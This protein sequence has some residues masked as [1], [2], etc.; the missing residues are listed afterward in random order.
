MART[1]REIVMPPTRT[2][3]EI[4]RDVMRLERDLTHHFV[5][6]LHL[7]NQERARSISDAQE[8]LHRAA[9]LLGDLVR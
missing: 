8:P 3:D 7:E 9:R 4:R 2:L 5:Y 6:A 1:K